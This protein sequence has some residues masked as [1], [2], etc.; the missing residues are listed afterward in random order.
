MNSARELPPRKSLLLADGWKRQQS[1][2]QFALSLQVTLLTYPSDLPSLH[3]KIIPCMRHSDPTACDQA[4][5]HEWALHSG[6][7]L[8]YGAL[9]AFAPLPP[10][11]L[12]AYLL[13]KRT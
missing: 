6:E 10:I 5:R 7:G 4:L 12:I 13:R 2:R 9:F 3:L 8:Y 1:H 11:W